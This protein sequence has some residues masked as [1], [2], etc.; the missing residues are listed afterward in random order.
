VYDGV[1]VR[2]AFYPLGKNPFTGAVDGKFVSAPTPTKVARIT[3]GTSKTMMIGEKYIRKD[4]YPGGC[5]S[6]D[7]G[8]TDG[9]DPDVMRSTGLPPMSDGSLDRLTDPLAPCDQVQHMG[10]AWWEFH[11]G[12]AHPGGINAVFA[13]GSVHSIDYSI[14]LNVFNAF[15]TRNG[16]SYG[17]LYGGVVST[18]GAN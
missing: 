3:D 14:D 18:E 12:S 16:T 15:G 11:F 2:S 13:D 7:T 1:I 17:E 9:W 8:W 6:D 5:S 4:L 10:T